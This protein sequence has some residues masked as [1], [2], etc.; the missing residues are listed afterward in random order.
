[1]MGRGGMGRYLGCYSR[2][3]DGQPELGESRRPHRQNVVSTLLLSGRP[4]TPTRLR[5]I[6]SVLGNLIGALTAI[7]IAWILVTAV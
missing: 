7:G 6:A 5:S 1:M 2:Q 3:Y 4:G